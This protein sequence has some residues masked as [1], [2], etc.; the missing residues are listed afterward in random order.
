MIR[1]DPDEDEDMSEEK[2]FYYL[3]L[4]AK[5]GRKPIK[6][7][8]VTW[9][10]E[11]QSSS[12]DDDPVL[13]SQAMRVVRTIGQAFEVC[14]KVAQ[15]QM[16]EK[17]EDEAVKSKASLASE[18]DAGV[19]LD[20][21]EERGAAE[22]SSRS[23]SPAEPSTGGPLYGR[24]MSLEFPRFLLSVKCRHFISI[25]VYGTDAENVFPADKY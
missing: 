10:P 5:P 8:F 6:T 21:I 11:Q 15:E 17:H 14:H 22:E 13:E 23:Q 9:S 1:F 7:K 16:L 25:N 2:R 12:R 24:R 3:R 20:V 19:P 18:D 4:M